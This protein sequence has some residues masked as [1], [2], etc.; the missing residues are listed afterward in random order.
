[1]SLLGGLQG[2]GDKNVRGTEAG[3]WEAWKICRP[4]L[5]RTEMKCYWSKFSTMLK[6]E[7]RIYRLSRITPKERSNQPDSHIPLDSFDSLASL[8]FLGSLESLASFDSLE[9]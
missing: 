7:T 9:S 2:G 5:S 1:M 6:L 4:G 8:E 3:R